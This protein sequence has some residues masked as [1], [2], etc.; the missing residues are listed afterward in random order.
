MVAVAAY[1]LSELIIVL[2]I[3]VPLTILVSVANVRY[4]KRRRQRQ[5]A[6]SSSSQTDKEIVGN[7]LDK[8][9]TPK[10][11]TERDD[12]PRLR[13]F[14]GLSSII[15]FISGVA[16]VVYDVLYFTYVVPAT[17]PSQVSTTIGIF[18]FGIAVIGFS[19]WIAIFRFS[20]ATNNSEKSAREALM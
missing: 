14:F 2:S 11:P 16:I 17:T 7:H 19:L 4:E 1:S 8:E 9:M 3:A 6:E 10:K 5:Q 20:R 12:R 18:V 13:S 15:G